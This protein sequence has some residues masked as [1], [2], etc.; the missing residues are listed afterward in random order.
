MAGYLGSKAVALSTTGADINGNANVD[1]TLDVLGAFTSLGIDDNATSTAITIDASGYVGINYDN[2]STLGTLVVKQEAVSRGLA[3]IDSTGTNTFYVENNTT[4]TNI[5]N[6]DAIPLIFGTNSTDRMWLTSS[7]NLGIGTASPALKLSVDGDIWQ[8]NTAGVEIGRIQ[9]EAGWYDVKGSN[10]VSGVQM[11]HANNVRFNTNSLERM[12]VGANGDVAINNSGSVAA[13]D[14]VSGLQIGNTATAS[15][16]I[17]LE[18]A[19]RSFMWYIPTSSTSL[20]LWDSTANTDRL[21]VTSGGHLGIGTAFPPT[22]FAVAGSLPFYTH[23][24]NGSGEFG[25]NIRAGE[26]NTGV[27]VA[28]FRY[29]SVT[30]E[31]RIGGLQA[32]AF[33]TFYSGGAERARVSTDGTFMVGKTTTAFGLLGAYISPGG[34]SGFTAVTT[35]LSVNRSGTVGQVMSIWSN[36]VQV[37]NIS[38]TGSNT[39]YNT[40]SDYRLKENIAPIQ[41]AADI[42]KAMRPATYTFKADGSW[43]D[44]FIAHELQELHP[45]AVTGSK[46]GMKDEEYEVTPAVE[47]TFDAEGVEL[48]PAEDAVMGTRSVPDYQGVDYSKLTPILTA[49]L[50]E[51]LNKI[52]ALEAQNAA[53][54]TRLTALEAKP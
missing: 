24:G 14:G 28:T 35:P 46:D 9:N 10:N 45:I 13:L 41:G 25:F 32:Y 8:G 47:A 5:I 6:N 1:G 43:A 34:A 40:S 37:G 26:A 36:T 7:G 11:S 12:R 42:V 52:D 54:E 18:T 39:T 53:F 38:V 23:S 31:N 15:S 27:D 16:G 50:Q 21:T 20:A 33:P 44:G 29:S 19:N 22:Q 48:T 17:A 4:A 49:A 51:A 2:P 3:I 30:G